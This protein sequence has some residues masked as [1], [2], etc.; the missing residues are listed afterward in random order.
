MS[1]RI[2][3]YLD[4]HIAKAVAQALRRRGIDVLRAH[5]AG[6][7]SASDTEHLAFSLREGRVVVTQDADF[8]RLDAE[9]VQHAGIAYFAQQLAS[10]EMVRRLV[11]LVEVLTPAEM[12]GHVEYC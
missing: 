9:G 6:L 4:E 7:E 5:E 11:V 12:A 2:R 3:L 1:E 8:L 10:G